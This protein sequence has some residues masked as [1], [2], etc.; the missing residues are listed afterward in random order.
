MKEAL[1]YKVISENFKKIN[2]TLCPHSCILLDKEVGICLSRKNI[3]G[4]LFALN[5]E[6]LSSISLDPVEKKPLYHFFPSKNV[7]SIGSWGC[8]FKCGFCQN[9]EISQNFSEHFVSQNITSK[10]LFY[11]AK[12]A[13]NNIGIAYTYNE[14]L[15]NIEFLIE[16]AQLF[17]KNNFKNIIVSNGYIN[18]QPLLDLIPYIDAANIDLK[19]FNSDF[20]VKYCEGKISF[21][22]NT[23]E[24]L[25]KHNI[26][27]EITTLIIPDFNDDKQ[28]IIKIVD[29][30]SSLSKD[31]PFHISKYHPNYKFNIHSTPES[32]LIEFYSIAKEKLNYVYLGNVLDE[33]YNS[34]FCPN[35][36]KKVISRMGY[37]INVL[38]LTKNKCNFCGS[39]LRIIN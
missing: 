5:Y 16:T 35:C 14:P 15:I 24:T 33:N 13:H 30:I 6:N 38:N 1:Y 3:N 8:N 12:K 22:L 4:K 2:C 34:T 37:K 39:D 19:S 10:K 9:W 20:Y 21:V 25:F 26:H 18:K 27:I 11:L 23:I 36:K 29:F 31:I 7:L 32:I 28:N 17:N